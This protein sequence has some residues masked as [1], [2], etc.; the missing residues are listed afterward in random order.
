MS[1][2]DLYTD[3]RIYTCIAEIDVDEIILSHKSNF[4]ERVINNNNA[5]D[6]LNL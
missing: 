1:L 6:L 2:D 3:N 4:A 5:I